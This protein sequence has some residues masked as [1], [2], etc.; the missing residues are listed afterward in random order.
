MN[1]HWIKRYNFWNSSFLTF[2]HRSFILV[3]RKSAADERLALSITQ[4]NEPIPWGRAAHF[5]LCSR[6]R[7][8]SIRAMMT[9]ANWHKSLKF[10]SSFISVIPLSVS[11]WGIFHIQETSL[12]RCGKS[13]SEGQ[14]VH[15]FMTA[16]EPHIAVRFYSTKFGII[17]Q[18]FYSTL[19]ATSLQFSAAAIRSSARSCT[20]CF[21]APWVQPPS[22][23]LRRQKLIRAAIF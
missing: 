20:M 6:L 2:P 19:T 21:S 14:T 15:R 7:N 9:S 10:S 17:W 8:S 18:D 4:R 22:T 11:D 13:A 1:I 23:K 12:T 5:F 16:P 3:D